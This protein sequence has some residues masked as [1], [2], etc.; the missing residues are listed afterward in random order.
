MRIHLKR[1]V[2]EGSSLNERTRQRLDAFCSSRERRLGDLQERTTYEVA[3]AG[4]TL[5]D[6]WCNEAVDGKWHRLPFAQLR[7]VWS[8][9]QWV[10]AWREAGMEWS[11][12]QHVLPA[13]DLR[14]LLDAC[15]ENIFRRD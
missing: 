11:V 3:G 13:R 2:V 1:T 8:G 9:R 6:E 14:Q 5:F 12:C 7:Y 4:V 15:N 10:L